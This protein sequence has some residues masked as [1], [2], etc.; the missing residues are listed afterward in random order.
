MWRKG[1][2]GGEDKINYVGFEVF[3]VVVLK[4]I[5]FWDMTPCSP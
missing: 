2:K 1:R 3:T 5:I 4:S